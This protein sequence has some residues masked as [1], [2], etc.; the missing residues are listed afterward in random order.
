MLLLQV[1]VLFLQKRML[2][3]LQKN[4]DISKI[5][6]VLVINKFLKLHMFLYLRTKFQV[7]SIT[8]TSFRQAVILTPSKA[9][10]TPK[11]PT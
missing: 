5:K 9:N 2:I 3:F 7:S 8:S 10:R 1:N 11:K 6:E 4:A